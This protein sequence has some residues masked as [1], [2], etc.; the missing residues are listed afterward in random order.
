MKQTVVYTLFS[1]IAIDPSLTIPDYYLL[2]CPVVII[3]TFILMNKT[4]KSISL[5][6]QPSDNAYSNEAS[7]K[8]VDEAHNCA[9]NSLFWTAVLILI[10]LFLS[11]Y[12][13]VLDFS[14]KDAAIRSC[15]IIIS[16]LSAL[17]TFGIFLVLAND[18]LKHRYAWIKGW[19]TYV[20]PTICLVGGVLY[21]C[22]EN[23]TVLP[24]FS[25]I[26]LIYG[27][28]INSTTK[29]QKE[30]T[31]K[32]PSDLL[33]RSRLFNRTQLQI[34]KLAYDNMNGLTI[35]I[36]GP[37]GSGKTFFID[38]LLAYL[39]RPVVSQQA[40]KEQW[41]E[42]FT[43]CKKVELW[44][45][46]S[47]ADAWNR[48]IHALHIG[49]F[50][51]PPICNAKA[52]KLLS[53]LTALSSNQTAAHELIE[54]ILPEFEDLHLKSIVNKMKDRKLVLVI[55]DLERADFAIIQAMLPLF[56]RLKRLPNLIV[57]CAIAEDEL[58]QIFQKNKTN[59][60]FAHG[61]LNKLFDLRIEIPT[62]PYTAIENF[63]DNLF[64]EKYKDCPMVKSFL[65]KYPL[66]FN[67][68]RQMVRVVDKLASV[69]HQ[70]FTNCPHYFEKEEEKESNPILIKAKYIFL[71][72]ALRVS[73][74]HVLSILKDQVHI[75]VFLGHIPHNIVS[76]STYPIT[77]EAS[78]MHIF[79]HP[80]GNDEE[81]RNELENEE[82]WISKYRKLY[83]I[84][85]ARGIELSILTHMRE[86]ITS[87]HLANPVFKNEVAYYDAILGS[88]T[89]CTT[90]NEWEI[91][92]IL[93]NSIYS[94]LSYSQMT[95]QYFSSLNEV[96]EDK[97]KSEAAFQL[98][99]YH[100]KKVSEH[101][102]EPLA[103]ELAL[104]AE[105]AKPSESY[106]RNCNNLSKEFYI[107]S[108]EKT[109]FQKHE[110]NIVTVDI[111][112]TIFENLFNLLHI[113][114][115]ALVISSYFNLM[116]NHFEVERPS[117]FTN[118][119]ARNT[120]YLEF[121]HILCKNYGY[122]LA[123]QIEM[124]PSHSCDSLYSFTA[125]AY[126]D[127]PDDIFTCKF[128]EGISTYISTISDKNNF[129]I[130]WLE[131]MGHQYHSATIKGGCDSSFAN[132]DVFDMMVYIKN[133]LDISP[134]TIACHPNKPEIQLACANSLEKLRTDY[135]NWT[136][137][138]DIDR[139]SKYSS[140]IF[141]II[142]MIEEIQKAAS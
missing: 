70:Y 100:I 97:S 123:E 37:W 47:L 6:N 66:R 4:E 99:K 79:R 113:G 130:K 115:Q 10:S 40:K 72:E 88:Y 41:N 108:I 20:I 90:L 139:K 91:E 8:K 132:N 117:N 48:I 14:T 39:S 69:E 142:E 56:E 33:Y 136:T 12:I 76:I 111:K 107:K 133:L 74:P 103:I 125:Q 11:M 105:C 86:D 106:V 95:R 140:G 124:Y 137:D 65:A 112:K 32:P 36:C 93:T 62:L 29:Q 73:S 82:K 5:S 59:A 15:H 18:Y 135:K 64:I 128:K 89:R 31:I 22:T 21:I 43:I 78:A 58:K 94:G 54:L 50:N 81:T 27:V 46:S 38:S 119:I 35:G 118:F 3:L 19:R 116:R 61:H 42:E 44:S 85:S 13:N 127:T 34:R 120:K 83:R 17:I 102:A 45:A 25:L 96:Q 141:F 52:K 121:M 138:K 87:H 126:R 98:L 7:V 92:E 129:I 30:P 67:S 131:F 1:S 104:E 53:F 110:N 60:E 114:E 75:N 24:C 2:P 84:L 63:Q 51:R 26:I 71:I 55:D 68:A 23:T 77:H 49:I 109:S 122:N 9:W 134:K 80:S 28:Y 57:I 16:L 101:R